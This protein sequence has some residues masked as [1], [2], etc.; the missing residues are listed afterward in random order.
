M[1]KNKKVT[2]AYAYALLKVLEK[3]VNFQNFS[4]LVSDLLDFSTL[5]NTCSS[6]EEFFSNPIYETKNKKQ[7]LIDFFGSSLSPLIMNFLNLLCDTKRII[8]LSSILKLFLRILL[9]SVNAY[10]VEIEIPTSESYKFDVNKLNTILSNWFLKNRK[11]TFV[12]SINFPC[13]KEPIVIFTIKETPQLLG[14]F[15]L[16]FITESKVIDFSISTKIQQI[17][18]VL[19][20]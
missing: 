9:K 8:Y 1:N 20:Y 6:I 18:K 10:I 15:K 7:F 12:E 19:E 17:T 4:V 13:F 16:N 14:G 2:N 5:F 11:E 3:D